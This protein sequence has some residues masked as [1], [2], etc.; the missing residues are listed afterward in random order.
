MPNQKA[1]LGS[2]FGTAVGDALGLPYEGLSKRRA[3]RLLG[4]P[5]RYRF[6]PRTGMVSD[7]T[8]H[9]CMVAEALILAGDDSDR[10]GKELARRFRWWL[11][12]LP[13]GIG[14]ATAISIF[15]LWLG[16][17]TD[18]SGVF[19][20]GNGPAM[21]SA[22]LGAAVE[23][24]SLL[25]SLVKVSSQMTHRDPKAEYG[26]W[27]V[28]LAAR[29][30]S[31]SETIDSQNYLENLQQTLSDD[32]AEE[33]LELVGRAVA[34][35]ER[36]ESTPD[37][38]ISLGLE[39]GVSGYTYHTVPMALHAWL[40]TPDDYQ[41]AVQ[42]IILC[43]GD[44]DSTAAIVGGI[45]GCSV[46]KE[47]IPEAWVSGLREWP[48]STSWMQTLGETLYQARSSKESRTPPRYLKIGVLPRN[49]FFLAVVLGHGFRRL[50]PPY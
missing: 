49:L 18:K 17:P 24:L 4:P 35:V 31:T 41:E 44:A 29:L 19:S 20:A 28:A 16:F 23:D 32:P 9:T 42:Q 43:G 39:K 8:E 10:F 26:A 11:A 12:S 27:A 3:P 47:G 13:A 7:D 30:A 34:S 48:R 38:G 21:R 2:M 46:G 22:I 6:L 40:S 1:I 25:R 50:L 36:G 37:F 15:K 5:D 45:V 14:K 33:F